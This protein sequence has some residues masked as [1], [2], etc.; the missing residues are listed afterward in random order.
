MQTISEIGPVDSS[1]NVHQV[2]EARSHNALS[3]KRLW[4]LW[5]PFLT[6]HWADF[7]DFLYS[8]S[9]TLVLQILKINF[10]FMFPILRYFGANMAF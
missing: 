9:L 8:S 5:A 6:I 1:K 7:Q 4:P 10:A 2:G 3:D